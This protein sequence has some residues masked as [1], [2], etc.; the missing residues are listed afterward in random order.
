MVVDGRRDG[1]GANPAEFAHLIRPDPQARPGPKLALSAGEVSV[2]AGAVSGRP[3]DVW[4]V[5]YDPRTVQVS[6]R[7]GENGGRTLP[8][9]NI[10]RQ[11]VR[12]GAWTGSPLTLKLP[13]PADPVLRTAILVQQPGGGPILAA[14]KG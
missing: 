7:R 3:A 5:R 14:A 8:H 13:A 1:V 12:L 4:L 2:G 11:L 10:V 9:R 6:I